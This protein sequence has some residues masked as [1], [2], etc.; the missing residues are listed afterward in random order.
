MCYPLVKT[1][2]DSLG[3]IFCAKQE[4]HLLLDVCQVKSSNS[5]VHVMKTGSGPSF[6]NR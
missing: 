6:I 2:K 1:V 3:L 5:F 4:L